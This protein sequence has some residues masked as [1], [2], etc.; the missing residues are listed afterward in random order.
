VKDYIQAKKE[1]KCQR[2]QQK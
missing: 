1:E 2:P